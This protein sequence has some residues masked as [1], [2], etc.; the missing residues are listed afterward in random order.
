MKQRR[1][2]FYGLI[3]NLKYIPLKDRISQTVRA[4]LWSLG[5]FSGMASLIALFV[6]QDMF[7]PFLRYGFFIT[8]GLWLLSYQIGAFLNGKY[9]PRAKRIWFHFLVLATSLGLGVIES[10]TPLLALIS[11]PKTFEV[12]RK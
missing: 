11:K 2:W 6:Y 10:A 8:T 3:Q 4:F 5:F 7:S 1:R 9:L 12:V